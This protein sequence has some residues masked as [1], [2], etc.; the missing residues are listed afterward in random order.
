MGRKAITEVPFQYVTVPLL[1]AYLRAD[2]QTGNLKG[3]LDYNDQL[4]RRKRVPHATVCTS[5]LELC[6]TSQPRH[7]QYVL[8]TMAEARTLEADDFCR[9]V[10]LLIMQRPEVEQLERFQEVAIDVLTFSDDSMH[11]YFAHMATLLNLEGRMLS[12]NSKHWG[13]VIDQCIPAGQ[14]HPVP[15]GRPPY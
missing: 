8:E 10:R 5:L 11:N 2:I 7:A 9:I 6:L 15:C 1:E 4:L 13:K 12:T 3:A 14:L